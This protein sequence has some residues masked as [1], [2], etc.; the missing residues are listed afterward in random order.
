MSR[1]NDQ[2]MEQQTQAALEGGGGGQAQWIRD[3][4][5]RPWPVTMLET[6]KGIE[7]VPLH[8]VGQMLKL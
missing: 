2:E 8:L 3:V 6:E 7:D 4:R 1:T 5:S